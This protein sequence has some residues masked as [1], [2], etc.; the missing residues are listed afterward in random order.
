MAY[1]TTGQST[2]AETFGDFVVYRN[3]IPADPRLPS[4]DILRSQ[5]GLQAGTLPRKAEPLYGTVVA[6]MLRHAR[7]VEISGGTIERLV[8]VGDTRMNDGTAFRNLCAAGNW[9]GWGFIGTDDLTSPAQTQV[10]A[11]LYLANRWSALPNFLRFLLSEE[12]CLD[13]GTAVV[14]DV[15]KTAIGARGRNDKVIDQAR[16]E[17]VKRTVAELLGP[18]FDETAFRAAY[19]ELNGPAYHSFTADNQ[20]YLAYICLLL[21]AGLWELEAL[22]KEVKNGSMTGFED[23]IARVQGR[24]SELAPTGLTSIHDS[25]WERVLAGD[26][27]PFKAFRYNEYLTTVARF[28]DLPGATPEELL[29]QRIVITEEVRELAA[30][31]KGRG[32]LIFG[33]SDKPDEASVPSLEQEREGEKPLHRLETMAVKEV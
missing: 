10:E 15:D 19:D 30:L 27:T 31:L 8:Y 3:L 12:V 13:E 2:L 24:R 6:E 9:P 25:V 17:G 28:A 4:V 21:G 16:V 26:P 32:C 20:D 18:R 1:K 29:A 23:F 33:V 11:P 7:R 22:I 5:L 14:I